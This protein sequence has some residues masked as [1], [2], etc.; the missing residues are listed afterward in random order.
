MKLQGA[1]PST[2]CVLLVAYLLFGAHLPERRATMLGLRPFLA[3]ALWMNALHAAGRAESYGRRETGKAG[4]SQ[5]IAQRCLTA[6]RLAPD[7]KVRAWEG[8]L[9]LMILGDTTGAEQLAGSARMAFPA[10]TWF[11]VAEAIWYRW[12]VRQ[13]TAAAAARLADDWRR[14]AALSDP[15]KRMTLIMLARSGRD[16]LA[17]EMLKRY[18][19]ESAEEGRD[20]CLAG[21][22]GL[23]PPRPGRTR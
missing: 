18:R 4:P 17:E 12:S 3:D 5:A 6:F 20:S 13:D 8:I 14:G 1:L 19:Q 11:P 23:R 21:C 16:D 7:I 2:A 15:I 10:D 22:L 9:L